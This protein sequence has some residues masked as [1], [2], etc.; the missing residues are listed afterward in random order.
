[1]LS[2]YVWIYIYTHTHISMILILS[3]EA[4]FVGEG[5]LGIRRVCFQRIWRHGLQLCLAVLAVCD[6]SLRQCQAKS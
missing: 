3:P 2:S 5:E 4:G 6:V 1:M